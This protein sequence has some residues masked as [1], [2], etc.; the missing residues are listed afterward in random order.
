MAS[1]S[2]VRG[3]GPKSPRR[4]AAQRLLQARLG[5]VR[6]YEEE[7][8]ALPTPEKPVH[9]MRVALRRLRIALGAFGLD[10]E[11]REAKRLQDALGA[12]RDVHVQSDW[13]REAGRGAGIAALL[14]ELRAPLPAHQ[15]ALATE[16]RRWRLKV[17]PML[18]AS[19]DRL[20]TLPGRLGGRRD[21]EAL[22]RRL[23]RVRRGVKATARS[24]ESLVAHALRIEL[25]KLRY[26]VELV[27]PA[28]PR[29]AEAVLGILVP[30]QQTLGALHDADVRLQWLEAHAAHVSPTVRS[31]VARLRS[32]VDAERAEQ[33]RHLV[34]ELERWRAEKLGRALR[35]VLVG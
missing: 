5:D 9:D 15:K 7:V 34:R 4:A 31:A 12:L 20:G 3:L 1:P 32:R 2:P 19:R 26:R 23:E 22:E 16:L 8:A 25:K 24:P 11:S 6:Q 21:R 18:V 27:A 14:Q 29:G 10:R 30:F 33:A 17:V 28:H 13:L 35:R